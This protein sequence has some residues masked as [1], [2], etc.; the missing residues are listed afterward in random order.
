MN[1][2]KIK[3]H[4]LLYAAIG[5]GFAICI[6]LGAL[7][8][9]FAATSQ[10]V[11]S[12]FS[13][14]YSIGNNIAAKVRTEKY[15]PNLDED[16]DGKED[17][18]VAITQDKTL[19]KIETDENSYVVFNAP[20]AATEKEVY[21]GK[22]NLNPFASKAYFYFTVESLLSDGFIRV[23]CTPTYDAN[24]TNIN[25]DI[26]YYNINDGE[27]FNS[28]T[29]ASTIAEDNWTKA[30]YNNIPAGGY[31]MIRIALSVN[32]I[33]KKANCSGI[34]DIQLDY[35]SV[36]GLAP[37]AD[38][39]ISSI[40][41]DYSAAEQIIFAYAEE[42]PA[43]AVETSAAKPMA[44]TEK[45]IW[46]EYDE[47]SL[48]LY[49][50]SNYTIDLPEDC[51][52]FFANRSTLTSLDL[53]NFNTSNVT[54]MASMFEKC[55]ALT[56][57]NFTN[58]NT[59]KVTNMQKMFNYCS[60][61]TELDLS[62]FDTSQVHDM[63]AMFQQCNLL[64]KVDLSSF[65]TSNVDSEFGMRN[66]FYYCKNLTSL[67]ISSF[68]TEKVPTMQAMFAN[69]TQLETLK[70]DKSTFITSSV[71]SMSSMFGGCNKLTNIDLSNFDTSKV[72]SMKQ[73]FYACLAMDVI[74][75]SNFDTSSVTDMGYMFY[76][77]KNTTSI[78]FAE[79][80]DTSNLTD[81]SY[82][83]Y[84]CQ[85]ITA[86]DVSNFNTGNVTTME[87]MFFACA[88]VTYLD[89][90]SFNTSQV[91]NMNFM[92]GYCKGLTSLDLSS[93]DTLNVTDMGAMFA[94]SE[95]LIW[96]DLSSFNAKN[97][98]DMSSMFSSCLNVEHIYVGGDWTTAAVTN[99]GY[100][101]YSCTKLP[102]FISTKYDKT[103]AY[104]GLNETTD[105]YGYLTYKAND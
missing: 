52:S 3:N 11:T 72:T 15:I 30:H 102:N 56:S 79:D 4:R 2:I 53:S 54:N 61:L 81:M 100:M 9:V 33:N 22:V 55:E 26:S 37:I 83:F 75:V 25:A 16:N 1:N 18:A 91:T 34:F 51:T 13:V 32:D 78:V 38:T 64:E 74:D 94:S 60:A 77:C 50:Y 27:S 84:Y 88:R 19:N 63:G 43:G 10:T 40:Q 65:D 73:M 47:A 86:L 90:S 36:T 14:S 8:G 101:F 93:F 44:D 105:K 12:S 21:I 68:N 87:R 71:T 39:T 69:C 82:M 5:F 103:Y 99:S 92:F 49:V 97:V 6:M 57:I 46:T 59:S 98:V 35:S 66:M 58:F 48:T 31:K 28:A 95:N 7:V 76:N 17:G 41:S 45:K 104:V 80:I 42:Q 70:F 96:I 67:D 89:L 62:H 23:T 85:K 20:D 24:K 29:S